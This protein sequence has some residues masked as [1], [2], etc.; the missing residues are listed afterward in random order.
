M[1]ISS[2]SETMIRD[3]STNLDYFEEF[4]WAINTSDRKLVQQLHYVILRSAA[5]DHDNL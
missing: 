5:G 2:I 4:F 1:E 3:R